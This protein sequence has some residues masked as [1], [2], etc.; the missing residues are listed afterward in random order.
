MEMVTFARFFCISSTSG[1]AGGFKYQV[2]WCLNI[3]ISDLYILGLMI[4][5]H[6]SFLLDCN[7]GNCDGCSGCGNCDCGS[8]GDGIVKGIL[9]VIGFFAG[10]A[11]IAY[12]SSETE[13]KN[14]VSDGSST[15]S[16]LLGMEKTSGMWS[17]SDMRTN[18]RLEEDETTSEFTPSIVLMIA[19]LVLFG[20]RVMSNLMYAMI[21]VKQAINVDRNLK[22]VIMM[23]CVSFP[24]SLLVGY[25]GGASRWTFTSL[26]VMFMH[27]SYRMISYRYKRINNELIDVSYLSCAEW[28]NVM[29]GCGSPNLET[30]AA[31]VTPLVGLKSAIKEEVYRLKSSGV[32]LKIMSLI[33]PSVVKTVARINL[34]ATVIDAHKNLNRRVGNNSNRYGHFFI[35]FIVLLILN[36]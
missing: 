2:K 10:A 35:V 32:C 17:G 31:I 24:L 12:D 9:S 18:R 6:F 11:G 8:S 1:T 26:A 3:H 4:Y 27:F 5:Y 33:Y 16:V 23:F 36:I 28:R 7:C 21:N 20:P 13:S 30:L 29:G 22:V 15:T 19:V 25:F 34:Q 14:S